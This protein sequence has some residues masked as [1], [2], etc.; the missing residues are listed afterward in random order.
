M[1]VLD[2]WYDTISLQQVVKEVAREEDRGR[3]A[4]RIEKA[5]AKSA[6]EFI[7]PKL[8]EEQGV[9]PRIADD[10]PLIFHPT[11]EQAPEVEGGYKD[12]FAM[13]RE[14]LPEHVRTLFD[15]FTFCDLVVKVVGVGSVGTLCGVVLF[16][17]G[18]DDPV[19]L[20]L[21]EAKA[22]VLEP[23]AGKSVHENHGQR[24]VAGQRLMQ[25]ASDIFLG[26]LRGLGGRHFYI[27][28][29]RDAKISAV[30]EGF[31][32]DLMQTYARLCAWALARAHAR[33]GDPAMIAG[34]MGA[35]GAFDDAIGEFAM[36]YADQ[37]EQDY[38]RFVTAIKEGRIQATADV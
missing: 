9:V 38:R 32:L 29:L 33:S 8:V 15:R 21:K 17:A 22:S 12:G 30:V 4:K 19:F 24:V 11:A 31:D 6:P 5:Q 26:W 23:Y 28:Q 10:P 35:G 1:H 16:L 13:Y 2:I 3:I 25:S 20:Q 37:N 27:R 14:S 34:Y 36:E 18:D 7:Y